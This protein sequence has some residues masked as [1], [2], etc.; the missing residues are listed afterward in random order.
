M[1][2]RKEQAELNLQNAKAEA[3]RRQAEMKY[4]GDFITY[5]LADDHEKRLR[6]ADYFAK[7][8]I[9]EDLQKRWGNYRDGIIATIET[10]EEKK[11]ELAKEAQKEGGKNE[12]KVRKL[13]SEV[14]R[15]QSQL[16]P[17]SEKSGAYLTSE[18][19]RRFL[20]D[21][22][23][24]PKNY[25]ENEFEAQKDGNVICDKTTGLMWQKSGSQKPMTY[26]EAHNY[27]RQLNQE[28]FAGYSDWRLPTL[29]EAI[30]L[31]K[32]T[33]MNHELFIGPLFDN[34]QR[35]IWTSD[36]SRVSSAWVVYFSDGDCS[37]GEV[38]S[39]GGYVRAVR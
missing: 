6:F 20:L 30:T 39:N 22:N 16:S 18:E 4:L 2:E 38:C 15:L 5:A 11:E 9:S 13:E 23:L 27:I 12:E 14:V 26:D 24:K 1:Q 8:T 10:L 17:L 34:K 3:E 29:K 28:G 37:N 36:L 25:T 33:Q 19:A 21:R 35:W 31:L 32:P 7:L